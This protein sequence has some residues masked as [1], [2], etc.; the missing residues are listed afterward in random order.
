MKRSILIIISM[1][2]AVQAA[3]GREE[4]R[5]VQ[6]GR[7]FGYAEQEPSFSASIT[8][9]S[10]LVDPEE[11]STYWRESYKLRAGYGRIGLTLEDKERPQ[12]K[13][14]EVESY[15]TYTWGPMSLL[16]GGT[17]DNDGVRYSEAGVWYDLFW[18]G[19]DIS[20]DIRNYW[21]TR[22][23]SDDYLDT[24]VEVLKKVNDTLKAG[25]ELDQCHYWNDHD[26]EWYFAGPAAYVRLA[27]NVVLY[28]RYSWQWDAVNGDTTRTEKT[29]LAVKYSF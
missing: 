26:H 9:K 12:R 24:Y 18:N 11:G 3:I 13:Y 2:L 25:V 5:L 7:E 23:G 28:L 17:R 1:L 16:A 21:Q 6:P 29:R 27:N 14:R 15:L 19:L 20:F 10:D 4:D 22:K 8:W